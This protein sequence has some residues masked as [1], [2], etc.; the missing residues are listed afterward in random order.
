M[1][2]GQ[3]LALAGVHHVRLPVSDYARSLVFWRDL[4]G[5]EINFEFPGEDGPAGI[6]L[7]H[8]NGGPHVVLWLDPV[9][10]KQTSGFPWF[11]IG[12]RSAAEIYT[13]RDR[14]DEQG[15]A[16]GGVQE[17]FVQ[18][19]LPFVEDPDGHLIGFYVVP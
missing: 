19:K 10:A 16:H 6:A 11:A 18:V 15:I 13:L 4:L 2:D 9:K 1:S 7:K 5:Y 14:F 17:A 12:C 3:P 8:A